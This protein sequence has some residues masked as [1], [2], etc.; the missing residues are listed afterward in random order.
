MHNFLIK[1]Q[2]KLE[3]IAILAEFIQS[4]SEARELKRAIAVKMAQ[5]G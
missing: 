5:S 3:K 1:Q 4:S 2:Q